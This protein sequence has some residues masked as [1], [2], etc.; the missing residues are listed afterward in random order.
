MYFLSSSTVQVLKVLTEIAKVSNPQTLENG[1]TQQLFQ[2]TIHT[3]F[4]RTTVS[5]PDTHT[6]V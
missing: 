1:T 5:V 2:V 6:I 3:Y 4:K